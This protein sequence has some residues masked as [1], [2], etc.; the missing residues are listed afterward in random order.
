MPIPWTTP[1]LNCKIPK[2]LIFDYLYITFLQSNIKIEKIIEYSQVEEGCFTI[3][4]SQEET[5]KF[6]KNSCVEVQCNIMCDNVRIGTSIAILKVCRNLHDEI[7]GDIPS[8]T[9]YITENGQYVV[10][11]F[12]FVDINVPQ[13][14]GEHYEGSYEV[15]P[16]STE[17]VLE[18]NQKLMTDNLVINP[19]PYSVVDNEKGLTVTI[20]EE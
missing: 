9:L 6:K 16:K 3:T 2:D 14:G 17:Q 11:G 18:T 1:S 8:Q 13:S 7:I 19:I 10:D 4:L 15:N 20:G 5:G 12:K